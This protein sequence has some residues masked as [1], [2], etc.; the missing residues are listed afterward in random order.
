MG[1]KRGETLTLENNENTQFIGMLVA[2]FTIF[3]TLVVFAVWRRRRSVGRSLI[4]AGLSNAGKTLLYTRLLHS[5]YVATHTSVKENIG[6]VTIN[7]SALRIVDIPGHERLRQKF[8]DNYKSSI[9]GLVYVIDSV[10]IQKDVRDVA[11]YLYTLLSDPTIQ[12]NGTPVLILCNKQDQ[13]TAKGCS[14]IKSLLEKEINLL[15][16]TKTNQLETT[17]ASS[18][19]FYLGKQGKDFEFIHLGSKVDFAEASAFDKDSETSADI[20]QLDI[21]LQKIA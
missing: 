12:K 5:K 7:N 18:S 17:D 9:R 6:D 2:V 16:V 8:F 10:T 4:L 21:W 1:N 19:N 3:I 11:E 15:R 20:E 13:T 14:V